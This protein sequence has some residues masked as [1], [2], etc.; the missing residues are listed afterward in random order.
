MTDVYRTMIE[1]R[2]A[3]SPAVDIRA[4]GDVEGSQWS[5]TGVVEAL[6]AI[7]DPGSIR[8]AVW[9]DDLPNLGT[10]YDQVCRKGLDDIPLTA[11]AP[12]DVQSFSVTF[13]LPGPVNPDMA[14]IMVWVQNDE[15][16]EV[17][18]A[19]WISQVSLAMDT[20]TPTVARGGLARL[21][22]DLANISGQDQ[23]V[24]AWLDA[25]LPN[26]APAPNNPIAGPLPL[27]FSPGQTFSPG[28]ALRVPPVAPVGTYGLVARIGES[29]DRRWE[30]SWLEIEVTP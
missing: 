27:V 1:E 18:Q 30:E 6:E 19:K 23:A 9:E 12:G 4:T 29:T 11:F 2:L 3:L 7:P 17:L 26:G 21:S 16:T 15:T 14:H 8:I 25:Y 24:E 20:S 13:D 28:L 5:V 22:F 10:R